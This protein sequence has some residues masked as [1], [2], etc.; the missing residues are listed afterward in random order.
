MN[1]K[2]K[3]FPERSFK[4]PESFVE[5]LS[6]VKVK[7]IVWISKSLRP[8]CFRGTYWYRCL[9]KQVSFGNGYVYLFGTVSESGYSYTDQIGRRYKSKSYLIRKIKDKHY[10]YG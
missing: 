4:N 10:R 3:D 9:I 5:E 1:T 7:D 8:Y 6:G 2:S